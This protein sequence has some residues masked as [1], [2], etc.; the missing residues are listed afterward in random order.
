[1]VSIFTTE[2]TEN[3]FSRLEPLKPEIN[4][5]NPY[6]LYAFVHGLELLAGAYCNT[7]LQIWATGLGAEKSDQKQILRRLWGRCPSTLLRIS[8]LT[9]DILPL[10]C[11]LLFFLPPTIKVLTRLHQG[12]CLTFDILVFGLLCPFHSRAMTAEWEIASSR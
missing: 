4:I 2:N 10:F 12:R 8:D 3:Y 1:M 6:T 7:P 11:H 9:F 5:R